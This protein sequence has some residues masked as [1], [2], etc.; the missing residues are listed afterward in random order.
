M[1]KIPLRIRWAL[2]LRKR[3][4]IRL[5]DMMHPVPGAFYRQSLFDLFLIQAYNEGGI[6]AM[7]D[8]WNGMNASAHAENA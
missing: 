2:A 3:G 4:M 5:S 1:K 6:T 7:R 8:T